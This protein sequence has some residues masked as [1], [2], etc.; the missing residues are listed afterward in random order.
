[1]LATSGTA[2]PDLRG[3]PEVAGQLDAL[4]VRTIILDG[5]LACPDGVPA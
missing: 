3:R 5:Q 2:P 1:M 4:G